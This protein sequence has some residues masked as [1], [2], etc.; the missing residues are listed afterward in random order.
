MNAPATIL[1][2]GPP[3]ERHADRVTAEMLREL[4]RRSATL[5]DAL[6]DTIIDSKDGNPKAQQKMADR[7]RKA[8]ASHVTL[9]PGKRGRYELHIYSE[10][11]WDPARDAEIGPDDPIPEKP[12]IAH[13]VTMIHSKGRGRTRRDDI[14]SAP[15]LFVSHHVLSRTAQRVGLRTIEDLTVAVT[16]IWNT[17]VKFMSEKGMEIWMNPPPA[18][19]RIPLEGVPAHHVVFQRHYTREAMVAATMI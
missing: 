2:A 10:A 7:L 16:V 12:W 18:G 11:G 15:I 13:R 3:P 19:H 9:T 1:S 5:M 4:A 14:N 6:V 8:G 17:A